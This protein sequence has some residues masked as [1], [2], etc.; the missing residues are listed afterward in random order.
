MDNYDSGLEERNCEVCGNYGQCFDVYLGSEKHVFD[1]FECANYAMIP[2]C[3]YCGCRI[4]GQGVRSGDSIFCSSD[5]V[6]DAYV[7]SFKRTV[8][9]NEQVDP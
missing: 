7:R 9:L 8:N 6:N 4:D 1:S 3:S 2:K 5:C